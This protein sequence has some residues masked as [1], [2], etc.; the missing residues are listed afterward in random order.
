MGEERVFVTGP[1][2]DVSAMS[3]AV[4]GLALGSPVLVIL[5]PI[6]GESVNA[7]RILVNLARGFARAGF[8]A[9]YR[10]D[11]WGTGESDGDLGNSGFATV[12][13]HAC[14]HL[15]V[16]RER[17]PGAPVVLV[18]VRFGALVAAALAKASPADGVIL[19]DPVESGRDYA[20]ELRY[21]GAVSS[22]QSVKA[23]PGGAPALLGIRRGVTI[24]G[25]QYSERF[26]S[27]LTQH[28]PPVEAIAQAGGR[29]FTIRTTR[30]ADAE[31]QDA[32]G[33]RSRLLADDTDGHGGAKRFW[34]KRDQYRSLHLEQ[35]V[36]DAANALVGGR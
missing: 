24:G 29:A 30:R 5:P 14:H 31:Q 11:Y 12:I 17:H 13:E 16:I 19:I 3:Y 26:L 9:A 10:L 15:D 22:R 18:A 2:G 32:E 27:E 8:G 35:A 28:A 1:R 7:Q 33:P 34:A 4:S 25:Y 6:G 23:A 21:C 20:E 36:W